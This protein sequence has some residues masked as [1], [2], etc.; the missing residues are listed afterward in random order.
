MSL[1]WKKCGA[2]G[3]RKRVRG[4][5]YCEAHRKEAAARHNTPAD[6]SKRHAREAD[7]AFYQSRAWRALRREA[8][9]RY[10]KLC[11]ACLKRG[12]VTAANE[13]DHVKPRKQY[14]ERALDIDNV[15]WLCRACHN[16]KR[17]DEG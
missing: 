7:H 2:P 12:R 1:P 5:L 4:A 11:A 9:D 3:C 14:P 17:R 13:L 10:G 8:A 6:E 16:R 15:Q